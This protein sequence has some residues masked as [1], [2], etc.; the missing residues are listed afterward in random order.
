[1]LNK[2]VM[3]L[4]GAP[5]Y[6]ASSSSPSSSSSKLTPQEGVVLPSSLY[7]FLLRV[8]LNL[9]AFSFTLVRTDFLWWWAGSSSRSWSFPNVGDEEFGDHFEPSPTAR[10]NFVNMKSVIKTWH[11]QPMTWRSNGIS[12]CFQPRHPGLN[13]PSPLKMYKKN[14]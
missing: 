13:P 8:Y 6:S 5:R 11:F 4:L 3:I 7:F 12:W 1:M 2:G 9:L 14:K 10:L